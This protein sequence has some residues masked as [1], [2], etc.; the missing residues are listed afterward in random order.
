MQ[1]SQKTKRAL[2]FAAHKHRNQMRMGTPPV[3]Y[4]THLVSV[5]LR[6]A[7]YDTDESLVVG[8]L[9]HDTLED[10]ETTVAELTHAFSADVASLVEELSED[11][12][13]PWRVRKE[14]YLAH[15]TLSSEA[16]LL[17]ALADKIDNLEDRLHGVAQ[18]GAAFLDR[19]SQPSHEHHW[20][21]GEARRIA[22]ARLPEHALTKE[23]AAL[24]EK[25]RAM[26]H[27]I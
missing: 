20:F 1:H 15:L 7:P 11:K 26:L 16:A 22:E 19:W 25:E 5:A 27:E 12:S 2:D 6:V 18:H 21:F 17:I 8:A 9:L 14:A 23:L 13:L 3:P 10:T 4:L 24:H